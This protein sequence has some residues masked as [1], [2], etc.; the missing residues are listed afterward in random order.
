MIRVNGFRLIIMSVLLI[1]GIAGIVFPEDIYQWEYAG[2]KKG[3]QI[4]T[5][6][7]QGKDY[8]AA[9]ASCVIP[10]GIEVVGEVLRDIINYPKWMEGCVE[11][12]MLK[13]YDDENDGFIFWYRQHI[14]MMTDRDMVLKSS[15]TI[16][17]SNA[18]G[19][20][21]TD[22]TEENPYNAEKGYIRM[23]SFN[24]IWILEYIDLQNTRATFMIDPHL[25]SELPVSVANPMIKRMPYKSLLKMKKM[26]KEPKYIEKGKISKYKKLVETALSHK[27]SN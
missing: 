27:K 15:V 22:L 11:T 25:G 1:A 24:S 2:E 14:P 18:K 19:V 4:Y 10:V 8:I 20:I 7:T 12:K 9:K 5:S 6:K 17:I 23:P 13:V 16:D 21:A 26:V 3:C